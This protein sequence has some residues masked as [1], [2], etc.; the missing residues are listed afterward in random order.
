MSLT[1][2]VF[3]PCV[4]IPC[5]NHGVTM[6]AVLQQLMPLGYP[7]IVIDDG[8]NETTQH[9]LKRL[10]ELYPTLILIR[11]PQNSGKGGAVI[12]G[13]QAADDAGYTHAVQIDADGQ[14]VVA[15]LPK[16]L[17]LSRQHPQ[18]LISGQPVYDESIPRSRLIGR[19]VTHVWVWI[20]TLSLSI[21]DSMCGFRVYPIKP[22]LQLIAQGNIGQHM[23]F[24]TEIMVR[25]YW[26]GHPSY[27]IPTNVV[28]PQ[29]GISH[30][31][32]LRDNVRIS[33]MHT[34]LFFSML[35]RAPKLLLKSRLSHWAE[36]KEV[37]GLTGM[38]IMLTVYRVMG[39][40][41][42]EWLLKPVVAM[43]WITAH[44]ARQASQQWLAQVRLSLQ[45]QQ[46][47]VPKM[48]SYQHFLRFGSTM[49]DK[50]ASWR[51]DIRLGREA[52][53]SAGAEAALNQYHD[54]G[55]LILA[56]HLGDIEACRALAQ[57]NTNLTITALVFTE[58]AQ[59][60]K[61]IMEEM[62]PQASVHLL[63]VTDIGPDTAILLKEKLN[64][65]EWVA[66]VG[67]RIAINPQRGGSWRVVWSSFLGQPAPFPQGPF[68][69]AAALQCPVFLMF[70]LRETTSKIRIYC[71][72]FAD[73]LMLP[74]ATRQKALQQVVDNYA[75]RLEYYALRS[76]LDWFNFYDFW[77]LPNCST[78][79]GNKE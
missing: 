59:R 15:D 71:E 44:Q 74:R 79:Q 75:A 42:F 43:Y 9:E 27:F 48:N 24:D 56:S 41:V 22:T 6:G 55:C 61:Q 76:P 49:L 7:C 58:H 50:V 5:Y 63:P 13:L 46:R 52:V 57:C 26:Q 78:D 14:H 18:A 20:E 16:L 36:K 35:P 38:R 31:D 23:D 64:R 62:A 25:L 19:W 53:F 54:Q 29:N 47:P 60:F 72:K 10:T 39:R 37:K 1:T 32:A 11:Q 4:V 70:A 45:H 3:L 21:K 28:Y 2:D 73:P 66:I 33:W 51:G 68:V 30:F 12:R 17:T 40:R 65:G 8:S 77:R 34:R 69:L 67:D